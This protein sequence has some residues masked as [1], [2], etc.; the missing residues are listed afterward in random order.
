MPVKTQFPT[1]RQTPNFMAFFNVTLAKAEVVWELRSV[2]QL[3]NRGHL[4]IAPIRA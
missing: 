1:P 3:L 2:A 4:G